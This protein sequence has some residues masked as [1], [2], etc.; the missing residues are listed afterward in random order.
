MLSDSFLLCAVVCMIFS[1]YV[2][3]LWFEPS[4]GKAIRTVLILLPFGF[5]VNLLGDYELSGEYGYHIVQHLTRAVP[6][7]LF[8]LGYFV[9]R[10]H[11]KQ[12][13]LSIGIWYPIN[14]ILHTIISDIDRRDVPVGDTFVEQYAS[15]LLVVGLIFGLGYTWLFVRACVG[16]TNISKWEMILTTSA[17]EGLTPFLLFYL[18]LAATFLI[19]LFTPTATISLAV[20]SLF[21][22]G[23]G[24]VCFSGITHYVW[25]TP[26]KRSLI[27]SL[28][29]YSIPAI[30]IYILQ[31]IIIAYYPS[32]FDI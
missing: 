25:N 8:L 30:L 6:L 2:A 4:R 15:L 28:C 21:S 16:K 10:N 13:L 23:A 29:C 20:A 11:W 5:F 14:H 22:I 26:L 17:I 7:L 32:R 27:Y 1:M 3:L 12:A 18:N 24:V 19:S 31:T 9:L